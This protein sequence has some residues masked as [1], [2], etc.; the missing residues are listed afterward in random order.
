MIIETQKRFSFLKHSFW[1][2]FCR[3]LNQ[4]SWQNYY[5]LRVEESR[6]CLRGCAGWAQCRGTC[7]QATGTPCHSS[8]RSTSDRQPCSG[9]FQPPFSPRG[10]GRSTRTATSFTGIASS[11]SFTWLLRVRQPL[12]PDSCREQGD[13][14]VY[15]H[16]L[17]KGKK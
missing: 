16:S 6:C 12:Q 13:L 2:S 3:R 11:W 5:D 17:Q 7:C 8:T 15:L 9:R 10:R 14:A 1:T 4:K